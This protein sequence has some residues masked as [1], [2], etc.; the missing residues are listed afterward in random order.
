M[1]QHMAK[2]PD[3]STVLRFLEGENAHDGGK[4]VGNANRESLNDWG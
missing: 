3:K 2:L 1:F 4:S